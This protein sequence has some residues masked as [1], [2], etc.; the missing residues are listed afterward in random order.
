MLGIVIVTGEQ[1]QNILI[2]LVLNVINMMSL[3]LKRSFPTF[4]WEVNNTEVSL[5][6]DPVLFLVSVKLPEML[7]MQI[8]MANYK[9]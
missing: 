2:P 4:V 5:L 3:I 1:L 7:D 6:A 8:W 9:S